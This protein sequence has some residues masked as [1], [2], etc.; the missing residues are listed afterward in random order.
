MIT[1]ISYKMN[2]ENLWHKNVPQEVFSPFYQEKYN[3]GAYKEE[4]HFGRVFTNFS[5]LAILIACLGLFGLV[6]YSTEQRRKEIG[7][8]KVMGASFSRILIYLSVD[9]TKWILLANV[10]A[11]P[12]SY[13]FMKRWLENFA[14]A[15]SIPLWVY[16]VSILILMILSWLT[17][18][19][20]TIRLAGSDPV[21]ALKYE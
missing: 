5:V 13:Y 8:R 14:F 19:F 20:L 16:I 15:T 4:S 17:I 7:I 21:K 9:F 3:E 6:A 12:V 18:L 10:L 1:L 2:I 11:I